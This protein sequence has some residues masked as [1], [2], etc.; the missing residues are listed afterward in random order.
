VQSTPALCALRRT[1]LAILILLLA[2]ASVAYFAL[3][4]S[5]PELD[6]EVRGAGVRGV[7]SIERD[8]LG[9]P[10]IRGTN[11]LD[12][13]WATGF[14][15]GQDRFFQMDLSR[16]LAAG[17]LAEIIG[18]L[19]LDT[20]RRMRIHR[21]REVA[22]RVLANASAEDRALAESYARGVNAARTSL[23]GRPFEYWL[24]RAAPT[25]WRVE[26][27]LLVVF[28]MYEQL[29]YDGFLTES[30]RGRVRDAVPDSLY[31]F[32]YAR[33]G[34][35]D[36]PLVGTAFAIEPPPSAAEFSLHTQTLPLDRL[37][38]ALMHREDRVLG[39]NNWAVAGSHTRSGAA[40]LADDMHLGLSIPNTWYRVRLQVEGS[41]NE[42]AID[43]TGV[44]LP[45]VPL[46][47]V[48]SNGRVAW[49]FTN[50]QGDWVD[51]IVLQEDPANPGTY[52]TPGGPKAFQ[53]VHE[54]IHVSG[55]SDETLEV[56]ETIWG[57]VF[58]RDHAGRRRA[59]AWIAHE[60]RATNFV[61][62]EMETARDVEQ[63]LGIAA[64][65]GAPPQNFVAADAQ[66]NIGWTI[67]GSIPVRQGYDS[68]VPADWSHAG[69]GWQGWLEAARYPRIVN[70]PQAKIW[71]ANARVIDGEALA[72]LGESDLY[73]GARARQIRDDLLPL[74]KAVEAD[75]LAIQLDDRARFLER[76]H[77]KL[78]ALL[79]EAAVRDS[80]Q[81][82]EFRR[83]L[84]PWSGHASVESVAYR[85]VRAWRRAMHDL[86]FAA[87][88]YRARQPN[89]PPDAIEVPSQFE[90]PL[91]QLLSTEPEHLLPA[92]F[93]SWRELELH[94]VDVAIESL[95][96]DC[97][98][99][100][101]CTWG[102]RNRV[103][104]RHPLGGVPL[105]GAYLNMPQT[106]LPGDS[107]MPRVQAVSFG[108]SERLAVSPGHEAQGYFHMPG[109]QSG[110]PLSRF[111]RAGHEAW[112]NGQP[113]PFLPGNAEHRLAV[114]P[115]ST[116]P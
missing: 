20:D 99:L 3:R 1:V 49:G 105:I 39:S 11:R 86:V 93:K 14:V 90:G 36:A 18:P 77:A 113:L 6:G 67:M 9:V 58:D 16:R 110:H 10:T 109:G 4:A 71:T 100:A 44:T 60:P 22:R 96:K 29:N 65:C 43:V 103:R 73:L 97:K 89:E 59:A 35:W 56:L 48:G 74:E 98:T 52:A 28:A 91:W 19:A 88:T 85:L 31:R 27:S 50:S 51:L 45:G 47:V 64:R 68:R 8:A 23:A 13:A 54:I 34:E 115:D 37:T 78:Q 2:L 104:I 7:T 101:A 62:R 107:H 75:M 66:G 81:R 87:L 69:T 24:L 114:V 72:L 40:L 108:A 15:H 55:A 25:E 70:P 95:G 80:P 111:Y 42:A 94:A 106:E 57:P 21:F 83:L 76:W 63:A 32:I 116:T 26:D 79:D 30:A 38:T 82:A 53:K 12:V 61:L 112:T 17:E 92:N 33:G 41:A 84:E 5:L 46:V 102:E